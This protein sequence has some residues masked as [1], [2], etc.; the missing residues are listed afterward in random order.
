M[1]LYNFT[2]YNTNL[3]NLDINKFININNHSLNNKHKINDNYL[4]NVIRCIHQSSTV[5]KPWISVGCGHDDVV[6][7]CNYIC[8]N[9]SYRFILE[10]DILGHFE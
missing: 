9:R 8:S 7:A 4:C 2:Y 3:N 10:V 5:G 6:H 1:I